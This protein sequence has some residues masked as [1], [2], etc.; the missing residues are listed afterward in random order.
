MSLIP[1]TIVLP[2]RGLSGPARVPIDLWRERPIGHPWQ[3]AFFCPA[4]AEVWCLVLPNGCSSQ[5][6]FS[7]T[8]RCAEHGNGNFLTS[9]YWAAYPQLEFPREVWEYLLALPV[10][11]SYPHQ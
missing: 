10:D 9:S 8:W 3:Y 6:F 1:A 11:L 7:V 5:P 4:C 2:K